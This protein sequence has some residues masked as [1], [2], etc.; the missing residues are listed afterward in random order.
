ML[1]LAL[2]LFLLP[3]A[4]VSVYFT[5]IFAR[6][7]WRLR[8]F[9]GPFALPFVGNCYDPKVAQSIFKYL[10]SARKR[11]GKVFTFFG[12]VKA[13]LVIMD[14]VIVRRVLSDSKT[15]PKGTD[16]THTF[17]Y[18]FGKGL[19][20][21]TGEK[22]KKDRAIF[23]KYFVRGN[24]VKL[25]G[26]FNEMADKAI[27]EFVIR[28]ATTNGRLNSVNIEHFFA[29]CALRLFMQFCTGEDYSKF[30]DREK[31][32][33]RCVSEASNAT[34][35]LV[36][37]GLPTFSFLPHVKSL[38]RC[39]ME[40]RKEFDMAVNNRRKEIADGAPE[41][42]DCLQA[43]LNDKEMTEKD[44]FDHFV[45]LICAGHDTS[46]YF[47][48][49]VVHVLTLYPE[50]QEKLRGEIQAH[51]K[52]RTEVTPDDILELPYLAKVMQETLRLYA[53][54]PGLTRTAAEEVHIKEAGI[55]IPK[56]VELFIPMSLINRDP[57]IW[58]NPSKFDP[59]RF[60][61]KCTDFTSAKNGFF[62]F[63]YGS[64]TCIGNTLAQIESSIIICKLLMKVRFESDPGFKIRI[65]SGI[66][67]TTKGGINVLCRPLDS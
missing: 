56:D 9:S 31:I 49:Y 61:G 17:S 48:S 43:M 50:V 28:K 34:G 33:C 47:S 41:R 20:T 37:F 35:L 21:S 58:E 8:K 25:S 10:A 39:L 54:I 15:F 22:H 40:V 63:G 12:F 32:I 36:L 18:L 46:A 5:F 1:L 42:D 23:G 62:P 57:T 24:I 29:V 14:P 16:Y 67:L 64:R 6:H 4:V 19:V 3:V 65:M 45:T 55:T 2:S 38:D 26:V 11:Y 66:S 27:D 44:M 13:R 60:D 59:E 51:F 52:G 53:I 30:P 7:C